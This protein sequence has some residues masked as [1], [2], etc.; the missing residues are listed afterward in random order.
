MASI[1]L[2]VFGLYDS[3]W[4]VAGFYLAA[5]G[6]TDTPTFWSAILAANPQVLD[7]QAIPSGTVITLP[8][9]S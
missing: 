2:Y 5:S 8:Y 6:Y 1:H 4:Q 9:L 3:L 7:P